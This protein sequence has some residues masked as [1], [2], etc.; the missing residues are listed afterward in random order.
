MDKRTANKAYALLVGVDDYRTFDGVPEGGNPGR[1]QLHGSVNDVRAWWRVCRDFGFDPADIRVLTSPRLDAS[2][3]EGAVPANLLPATEKNLRDGAE[4]VA[5]SIKRV[6]GSVGLVVY[7]GHG[8]WI[9]GRGLMLCPTDVT[10]GVPGDELPRAVLIDEL[11][12]VVAKYGA[13]GSVTAVIDCC[14]SHDSSDRPGQRALRIPG[15]P[16]G[17]PEILAHEAPKQVPGRVLLGCTPGE[18]AFEAEFEGRQL[19]AFTWALTSALGQWKRVQEAGVERSDLAY[20]EACRKAQA[21]LDVL[22]FPQHPRLFGPEGVE[23]MAFFHPGSARHPG[24]TCERPDG[25]RSR[26][27]VDPTNFNCSYAMQIYG[28]IQCSVPI[29]AVNQPFD[30]EDPTTGTKWSFWHD[31]EYWG[32]GSIADALTHATRLEFKTVCESTSNTL[33][34]DW[35]AALNTKPAPSQALTAP[36]WRESEPPCSPE[37]STIFYGGY[38]DMYVALYFPDIGTSPQQPT[39]VWYIAM[40]DGS[41]PAPDTP[42]VRANVTLGMSTDPPKDGL[43]WYRANG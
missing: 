23:S 15:Q 37:G 25:A 11:G 34:P 6:G 38:S 21:L 13:A 24:E 36:G 41:E 35:V 14:F 40:A 10:R 16:K 9:E 29:L 43:N 7:S 39:P 18:S 5:S 1:N 12:D 2:E 31:M 22:E 30:Y 42:A 26:I 32:F 20:G 4:W 28:E 3:L 27:Q 8:Y 17:H 33:P 19:G